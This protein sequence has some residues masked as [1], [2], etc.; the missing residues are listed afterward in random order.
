[1]DLCYLTKL[2]KYPGLS[3][4]CQKKKTQFIL[5]KFKSYYPDKFQF[6]PESYRLPEDMEILQNVMSLEKQGGVQKVYIAKPTKGL[7][8]K[9]IFL[10]RT[11]ESLLAKKKGKEYVVQEYISD[12]LLIEKKKFDV[13]LYVLITCLSPL[14][15]YICNEGMCRLCTSEYQKPS[16]TNMK[17]SFVHLTNY[18]LNKKSMKYEIPEI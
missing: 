16:K 7:Q 6:Q 10:F 14:T 17:N 9:G 15:A 1:M 18:S 12:P 3:Y 4:L 8:G 11:F 5:D 13:R 2:N